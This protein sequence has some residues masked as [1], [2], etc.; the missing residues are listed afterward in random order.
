VKHPKACLLDA[1]VVKSTLEIGRRENALR[2]SPG[3]TSPVPVFR[4][5]ASAPAIASP[6]GSVTTPIKVAVG[7]CARAVP[8]E[9]AARI[10]VRV[11]V[12]LLLT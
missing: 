12:F 8:I 3:C 10:Q 2:A 9:I 5:T 11:M 4:T 1:H 6:A 7:V